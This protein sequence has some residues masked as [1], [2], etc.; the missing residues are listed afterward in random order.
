MI[1]NK[2][3]KKLQPFEVSTCGEGEE[4]QDFLLIEQ[5]D[6]DHGREKHGSRWSRWLSFSTTLSAVFNITGAF[7]FIAAYAVVKPTD[8]SC[9]RQ[10]STYCEQMLQLSEQLSELCPLL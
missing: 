5:A 7:L 2:F 10:L 6:T 3:Y 8:L 4:C 1:P 9:A